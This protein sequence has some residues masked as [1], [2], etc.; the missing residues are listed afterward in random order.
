[1]KHKVTRITRSSSKQQ[2]GFQ[3]S[4]SLIHTDKSTLQ[5]FKTFSQANFKKQNSLV[6][7]LSSSCSNKNSLFRVATVNFDTR[8]PDLSKAKQLED[9]LYD[10]LEKFNS[11][12][13]EFNNEIEVLDSIFQ[14]I[15]IYFH[16]FSRIFMILRQKYEENFTKFSSLILHEKLEKTKKRNESLLSKLNSLNLINSQLLSEN[17]KL[18]KDGEDYE[19]L[20]KSKPDIL[21]N[22]NNIIDKMLEQCKTIEEL[23]KEVKALKR[24]EI[25]NAKMITEL[26][27]QIRHQDSAS[28]LDITDR[29]IT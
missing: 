18:K 16:S 7:P 28:I 22:Y 4:L 1:M 29:S 17:E 15:S 21:I 3:S 13:S 9:L 23:R 26:K 11:N 24:A 19:R 6:N 2:I 10:R 20:F 8:K 14:E 12:H 25:L 5:P 27:L